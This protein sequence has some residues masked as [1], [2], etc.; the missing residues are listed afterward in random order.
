MK[1]IKFFHYVPQFYLRNFCISGSENGILCF[2]KLTSK[3]FP[4]DIRNVGG[5]KDFYDPIQRSISQTLKLKL[6]QFSGS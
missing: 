5:A 2:D 4:S 6:V 1:R 3:I